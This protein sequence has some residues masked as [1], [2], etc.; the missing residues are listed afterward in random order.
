MKIEEFIK[1]RVE[2]Q[3]VW[4]SK[5]SIRN[6]R[7]YFLCTWIIIVGSIL[8]SALISLSKTLGIITSLLV[9]I[10]V[11]VSNAY[12]FHSKWKLYRLTAEL[13]KHEKILFITG[14]EKYNVEN[15]IA[16][17]L[18][19]KTIEEILMNTNEKWEKILA[20]ITPKKLNEK[21]YEK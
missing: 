8:S 13:L 5:K 9:A 15:T 18:F 19:V 21:E 3:I 6:K 14:S 11:G 2:N 16:E 1:Q 4:H 10:S 12:K 17:K 7:Y 20:D